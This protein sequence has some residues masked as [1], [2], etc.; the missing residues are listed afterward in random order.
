ML[1]IVTNIELVYKR[2]FS[3]TLICLKSLV[4]FQNEKAI[5]DRE[6]YKLYKKKV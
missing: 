2:L 4:Q 1:F 6:K 3:L 5:K